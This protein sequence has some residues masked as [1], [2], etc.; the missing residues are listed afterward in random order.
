MENFPQ[1][2][3]W[4]SSQD[5]QGIVWLTLD[6]Q[7]SSTNVLDSKVL[8]EF[9]A[10]L[11]ALETLKPKG[12]VIQSA[13]KNGFIAGADI[14]QFDKMQ[15]EEEAFSLIRQ[16]QLIFQKLAD[17][18]CPSLA[19]IHGF[20]LGG[21]LELAL[22]CR[23]RIAE[24]AFQTKL[25]LPEVMLGIHPGWGGTIRLPQLIGALPAMDLIL[26]GRLLSAATALKLGLIDALVP[27]RHLKRAA[28]NFL[29]HQPASY[30]P[31]GVAA[32]SN[33]PILRP[34]LAKGLRFKLAAKVD[35]LQYPAP[36]AAV[37]H[38]LENGIVGEA[39]YLAE[40]RSVAQLMV[41]GTARNLL[42]VFRLREKLKSLHREV[43]FK[44]AHIHVVGAGV[45]GGDIAAWIALKG[46]RV[47][48]Q[49]ENPQA[50]AQSLKR[51][52]ALFIQHL[53]KPHLVQ[54]AKDRLLPDRAGV[55]IAKADLIIEAIIEKAEA[56]RAL[57]AALESRMKPEA[58]LASNT[59]TL[60]LEILSSGLKQPDRLVGIHFFN[61][62]AK[63]P[64]VE[65]VLG[66][67]T[68]PQSAAKAVSWLRSLDK[69]P[70]PV[71]SAAGFL[72]NRLLMPYLEESLQLL[73][74]GLPAHVI[75]HA[76][77]SFGLP[78]G[79]VELMDAVGL[80]V[81]LYAMQGLKT[82]VQAQISSRLRLLV[83]QNHL[84][85]KTGQGFYHYKNGK[86][87][88]ERVD[89]Q[90][91]LPAD[92]VDRLMLRMINEAF[93]CL[94]EKIVSEADALDAGMIFGAG[95]PAFR[96]GPLQ[97]VREQGREG[98]L[99]RLNLLAERYGTRFSADAGWYLEDAI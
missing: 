92:I 52:E 79:P 82:E 10:L 98:V 42:R 19:L 69:L 43:S 20:C 32:I 88:K 41:S 6:R 15:E 99:Q 49:D 85:R 87:M 45:M 47:T 63:M 5:E 77:R 17:L 44:P 28:Q 3:Q 23:Y 64:L 66:Q 62:V 12:L 97:Y 50:I 61:P 84:G 95:F 46:S 65:V 1:T 86:V 54:A 38:F 13:K 16:G 48:L 22:A 4:Q 73:E 53:K 27:T 7:G 90:Y 57:F 67:Q 2:S 25:G 24:E 71:K 91:R 56:K 76:A 39:A 11:Q 14:Q 96:G 8:T 60:P 59:S 74:E 81:C 51:A 75:D 89:R 33:W 78:M 34:L 40:A 58:I 18:P 21:G 68:D 36:Y 29:E 72:V 9:K 37:H 31:R 80:D 26:S 35:Q 55:G 30:R 93:A 70:L 94:R 83:E